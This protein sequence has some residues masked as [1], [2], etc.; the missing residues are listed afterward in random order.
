GG[1]YTGGTDRYQEGRWVWESDR[2]RITY[3]DWNSGEP[4]D[5]KGD[6][7][8]LLY[9]Y[10]WND[11]PCTRDFNYVCE[12]RVCPSEPSVPHSQRKCADSSLIGTKCTY[13]CDEGYK[14]QGNPEISCKADLTWTSA[15]SCNVETPPD[16]S[17][18]RV[19]VS[20][21]RG[22]VRESGYNGGRTNCANQRDEGIRTQPS[23]VTFTI[24]ADLEMDLGNYSRHVS[25]SQ[26]GVIGARISLVK[27]NLTGQEQF[28]GEKLLLQKPDCQQT[29]SSTKPTIGQTQH[30]CK[31]IIDV[32]PLDLQDGESLCVDMEAFSGGFYELQD[33]HMGARGL[34]TFTPVNQSKRVCFTY[35]MTKPSHCSQSNS[36]PCNSQPLELSTRLTREPEVTVLVDGWF[37]PIPPGGT[38]KSASH[39]DKYRLEVH[40]VDENQTSLS[41]QENARK[42]YSLEWNANLTA[43][44][45]PYNLTVR[46]PDEG[47]ARLYAIILE[48]HD[49]AGNVNYARRLVLYDNTS[50]VELKPSASLHVVSANPQSNHQ[51]QTDVARDICLN[52]TD[53]FYNS[54]LYNTNFLMPVKTDTGREIYGDYDQQSGILPITGTDNVIGI[55]KFEVLWSRDGSP[56]SAAEEI[57][58]VY[59]EAACVKE[60]LKDGETYDIWVRAT[61]IMDNFREDSV[62]VSIDHTGPSVSIEGLRG[63]FGRDGLYVHNTTDLS[64]ML[65]LVHA[66]DPH[67]GIKTLEWTLGTRDLSVDVGR[68]AIGVNRY[69]NST[70]CNGNS[71]CYCPAVGECES[72]QYLFSFANLV[73]NNSQEGQHHREYYIT[74]TATN[75]ASLRSRQ[76]MDIL[77]DES[78]PTVGVVLEGLSDDD[79]AEMDFTSSDVVHARWHG[80]LDHE[81]GILLYRVVLADR[82]LTGDEMDATHNATE[83]QHGTMTS[84]Q[85]PAEG[86]YFV[87]VVAYNGAMKPSGVACSDGITYD[88]TPP[89]LL[90][91]SITHARTGSE[92][93]CTQPDQPWLVNTNITRVRL[94]RTSDCLKLCTSLPTAS[95][96]E[97]LPVSSNRTIEE[98]ASEHFCRT[99]P[100]MTEDSYIVLPSDYLKMKWAAVD[101]ES[102]MEEYHV[103]M[104]RD[105]TTASA[106]DLLPFTPT[107]GHHSYHAR[108]SGLGHGAVFFIFLRALS[109]AGLH[110][111]LTLGPVLID[112]TPP[113]AIGTLPA[114]IGGDFL[115]VTWTNETF[116]DPEQPS[117][118]DF[119]VSFRVG[120]DA[121][122]VSPFLAMPEAVMQQCKQNDVTGCARYPIS[123]LQTHDTEQG[124][125]FFFQLHV[126]NAAGHVVTVNTS[127]AHLPSRLPP[128]H[129]MV[130][131]VLRPDASLLPGEYFS[132]REAPSRMP[133]DVDV[134]LETEQVCLAWDSFY[135]EEGL[136]IEVGLGSQPTLDDII[137]FHH[138]ENRS[139]SCMNSSFLPF[140]TKL[141]SVIRATGAGGKTVFS[142]D[143]YALVPRNDSGNDLMV[144]NGKGCQE[145]DV[146]GTEEI[147]PGS[148]ILTT[149]NTTVPLHIGDVVFVQ[150]TPFI[151]AVVFPDAILLQ[152]TL[153]G[154]QVLLKSQSLTA[155]LTTSSNTTVRI[156]SCIKDASVLPLP[157][158][159]V[160]RTWEMSGPCTHYVR[161]LRFEV[162]DKTCMGA[163]PKKGKFKK[164]EC[165]LADSKV[166]PT[167]GKVHL[168]EDRA[169]P[170]HTYFTTVDVCFD[171]VC[172][173][174]TESKPVTY[175]SAEPRVDFMRTTMHSQSLD[176][177]EIEIAANQLSPDQRSALKQT[178]P[179]VYKWTVA[180]D[181]SGSL[182]MTNWRVE[183]SLNCSYLEVKRTIDYSGS[184]KGTLY[185]CVQPVF[186]RRAD[187]PTCHKIVR[188]AN[189]SEVDPLHIIEL[190]HATF[191]KTDFE[192]F[193][194]S[195]ALGSKLHELYDMDI[196]FARSDVKLSAI[197]TDGAN[198][199]V[200]WFLMTS[201]RAPA[202]GN[203][204][205]DASCVATEATS[206]G[207]VVFPRAESKLV[208]DRV[209]FV[210]ALVNLATNFRNTGTK[211][212]PWTEVCGDG[213][214]IDDTPPATGSV[215]ISNAHSGFLADGGHVLVTWTGF[216]DVET[217]VTNL[218]DESTVKY[219]VALGSYPGG[220]DIARSVNVS[221][222]TT[223]TF[224]NVNI[225]AGVSCIA[226]VRAMDRVGLT[227]EAWSKSFIIDSTPPSVERVWVG[228]ATERRFVAGPEIT[229]H[230]EQVDDRE[231]GVAKMEVTNGAGLTS[232]TSSEP[233]VVDTSP[234][235]A[236]KVWNS[237]PN[238]T[239]HRS[240]STEIGVYRV[241][242]SPFTDPH[243]GLHY[244]RVGLGSQASSPD[245]HPFV[246]VGLQTSFTWRREFD[247]GKDYYVIVEACNKAGLCTK[248]SSTSLTFDDSPPTS[249]HVTVGFDGHHSRFL[250]HNSSIPVQWTGFSDPQTGIAEFRW[251]VGTTPG[252]CDVAPTVHTL[253]S[254]ASVRS[255]LALPVATSLY[256]TVH[257]K[258]PVGLVTTGVSDT[259]LVDTTPP[260]IVNVPKFLSPRD[261]SPASSQWDRSV[262]HLTWDFRDPDSTVVSHTV[263]IRSKVT[264]RFVTDP[265]ILGADS[266]L[267]L[268]LDKDH[269]LLD[270]DIHWA[271]V[272]ACNAAGLCSTATSSELLVDSTPPV[273]GTFES[274]LTWTKSTTASGDTVTVANITWTG[275]SDAES[276]VSVYHMLVGR[277]YNG[278]ELSKGVITVPHD[279]T[280]QSQQLELRVTERVESG[281]VIYMS[282]WA[283]NK[284][285]LQSEITR[286][287]FDVLKDNEN[288]TSGWLVSVRHSCQVSYCTKECTC[289]PTGQVC[290]AVTTP[291]EEIAPG[292]SE[293]AQ[294]EV[295]GYIGL[296]SA[297]QAFSASAKC[298]EGHWRLLTPTLL[299]NISRFE[300]SFSLANT[301]AGEGVFDTQN[302]AVWRDVGRNMTAVLCLPGS[303]VLKS[304][305][306]YVLHVRTWISR[307]EHVTFISDP[308]VVDHTPPQVKRGGAVMESDVDCGLDRDYV[309]TEPY[310]T[311]CWDGVFRESQSQL[312]GFEVSIG[313]SPYAQDYVPQTRVGLNTN[314]NFSTTGMEQ[315]IRYYVTVRAVN[316]AGLMTTAV[317]DGVTVDVTPPVAGV[318]FNTHGH[319]NRHAQ[320]STTTMHASWHGFDDRHSG[321]TSYQVA[322]YDEQDA[323]SPVEPFRDVDVETEYKVAVKARDVAGLESEVVESASILVD[324]TPPGGITCSRYELQAQKSLNLTEKPSFLHHTYSVDVTESFSE[325]NELMK[326]EIVA[327]KLDS[328]AR[329]YVIVEELKLPIYFKHSV[330]GDMVGEAEFMYSG[331]ATAAL[332]VVMETKADVTAEA[333]IYRCL[334]LIS[335]S[336]E[337]S[338]FIRQM[339]PFTGS[340]STL[341]LDPESGTRSLLVGVGT[342]PGGLQVHPL[343]FIGHQGHAQ[344]DLHVQHGVPLYA[345]VH[346][347]NHAGQ[348]SRFISQPVTMDR[349][350]PDVREV[351]VSLNYGGDAVSADVEWTAADEQSGVVTCTCELGGQSV[352]GASLQTTSHEGSGKCHWQLR[353]PQHGTSVRAT[354]SCVNGIQLHSSVTS[355]PE[356]I[357]LQPPALSEKSVVS[358]SNNP[359]ISPFDESDPTVRSANTSLEFCVREVDDTTVS[360]LQYRIL[361]GTRQFTDWVTLDPY[362]TS[363]LLERGTE[364]FP[365]GSLTAQVRAV[366]ERRMTSETASSVIQLD[367]SSPILTDK[368]ASLT[369]PRRGELKLD[370]DG[371]FKVNRDVTF[372]MYAGT[373]EGYG[374]IFNHVVTK[375][376]SFTGQHTGS[377]SSAYVTIEAVYANGL[378]ETYEAMHKM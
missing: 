268:T 154:Y 124:R 38:Y 88:T 84:F 207:K 374:D 143:G 369:I 182:L 107:H 249:G 241:Y 210:C 317:S 130:Y 200:T 322:L 327:P 368:R 83:V 108:H 94:A 362:K 126:T 63:R 144:F 198:R 265:V 96:I 339:S 193:L 188:P 337:E 136:E 4:N 307:E 59:A 269:L 215:T 225:T 311:A 157:T 363:V 195:K 118:V 149:V 74:I 228:T 30:D 76:M 356:T 237:A 209:Y 234:P 289:A 314:V 49:K 364:A 309:T 259:F 313:T 282:I 114:A 131:D 103:G 6:E 150:F 133:K 280:L 155:N 71:H 229:L 360:Q 329:G 318:V 319:T 214:V 359:L 306:R 346:A 204:A 251:C 201:R 338:V 232:L 331:N 127:S 13:T 372:S 328:E 106:P 95:Y 349:T 97:H 178:E 305:M 40:G 243:S 121:G 340:V 357:L 216:S 326:V 54:D 191:V 217:A 60:R 342:T 206:D 246:Y 288:G 52:W 1:Y 53:R 258:N 376:T 93:A 67:S 260:E 132:A 172:I 353:H 90:N 17:T 375:E 162:L 8:C 142:S 87:S 75:H 173:P 28:L 348:W 378:S 104:G 336:S 350:T 365:S 168:P 247:Q 308:V 370:W 99:L 255:G 33:D 42:T 194:R 271:T 235:E 35:D 102:E 341:V 5:S 21:E 12:V 250:G 361:H 20:D 264:G 160:T 11:V 254:R 300:W 287:E 62:R 325:S 161:D 165:L 187:N 284:M 371:V 184:G 171:D 120:H 112:E 272:T 3:S 72:H 321:V 310:L 181:A 77:I 202:D 116:T 117:D 302:E 279:N 298:L 111:Q 220:E 129:A 80:F 119:E 24:K 163:S 203:C 347:E 45:G 166:K 148:A 138:A 46:L 147:K 55:T 281:D 79:Q 169:F 236:G 34:H 89:R 238:T 275:F 43:R 153:T 192:D 51:W 197:L 366:N 85:F 227:T 367:D 68:G 344:F 92:V 248:S 276:N 301:S 315:G 299:A 64:S 218:P 140:Y 137:P 50:T 91:V 167:D 296:H 26:V 61:D 219:S 10:H 355:K 156:L 230:W 37:D 69:G 98:E 266:E 122:F 179:C 100:K 146:I 9:W 333:R 57:P 105:R 330:P 221:L 27:V 185:A 183:E 58:D 263:Q 16:L 135:R 292:R 159:H 267:I 294:F 18:C 158:N 297:P 226:T 110:V 70:D 123:V 19:S 175:D 224:E 23:N 48:V 139:P 41:V 115:M 14:L 190:A 233:F 242:W 223:W 2:T 152:T 128:S 31:G 257:A 180:R 270:G 377:L 73:H 335:A 170:G 145:D 44:G 15:P 47:A 244:Y 252:G 262:L 25:R 113:V 256:V 174:A 109:K 208:A 199:N 358:L 56:R 164:L 211:S 239:N 253:L 222:R 231:S 151:P 36:Q 285:G 304:G 213:V 189:V 323:T 141:F 291:C 7:D 373:A 290:K 274:P 286:M 81:S 29:V 66:A 324:V 320:S 196:D 277:T 245:V 293:R 65:L 261:E 312:A 32:P 303:R 82:C 295:A 205:G 240:Y 352:V 86:H 212:G 176:S 125:L 332:T 354:V 101:A 343:T 283:E 78:P 134:I 345:T 278:E 334:Q 177:M 316:G 273:V 22:N 186:P 351:K 39:I